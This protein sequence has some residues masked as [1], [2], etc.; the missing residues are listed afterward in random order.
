M[1][2]G[3]MAGRGGGRGHT[4][5]WAPRTG[6]CPPLHPRTSVPACPASQG[7]PG[8]HSILLMEASGLATA[9]TETHFKRVS[10]NVPIHKNQ[11]FSLKVILPSV[12]LKL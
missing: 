7:P 8:T 12:L 6:T 5:V 9:F 10:H 4:S 11:D 3:V 1:P 2:R